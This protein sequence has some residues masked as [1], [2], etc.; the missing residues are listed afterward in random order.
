MSVRA[1]LKSLERKMGTLGAKCRCKGVLPVCGTYYDNNPRPV[2]KTQLCQL[3]GR[4]RETVLI[5][6]VYD[7]LMPGSEDAA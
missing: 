1:R 2:V 6:V 4:P 3:C 5:H 7:S